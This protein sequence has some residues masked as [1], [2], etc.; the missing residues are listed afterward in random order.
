MFTITFF[1]SN[2]VGNQSDKKNNA[3]WNGGQKW[4]YYN[5]ETQCNVQ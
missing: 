1:L 4:R 2:Y 3:L 5:G